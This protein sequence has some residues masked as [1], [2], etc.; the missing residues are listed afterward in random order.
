MEKKLEQ[1][2]TIGMVTPSA[3]APALFPERYNRGIEWL[4]REGFLIKEGQ[5]VL[6]KKGLSSASA[7][8]RAQD[9][10]SLFE[11]ESVSLIMATIGGDFASE[12]LPYLDWD[13]IKKNRKGMIGYSD[14]SVLLNAI[15]VKGHQVVY[16]GPTLMTE[17][18]EYPEPPVLSRNKLIEAFDDSESYGITPSEYLLGKGT[19]WAL[20]PIQRTEQIPVIQKTIR[21]GCAEGVVLGG[22]LEALERIRGTEYWADYTGAIMLAETVEEKF[23]EKKWR[24]FITDYR[25]M[26]VL[27]KLSGLVIGQKNW[28]IE[29]VNK[30]SEMLTEATL[31]NPI[32][33]LYGLPFGHISPIATF[34][35]FTSA[36]LD[37]DQMLLVYEK[38]F[39]YTYIKR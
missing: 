37:A 8:E 14:I 23:D 38:P 20:P 10:N 30:L 31:E 33:I 5:Y 18:A 27:Q 36:K 15:G 2:K 34:P 32:P 9:I 7:I 21:S 24:A 11:D 22:C 39:K 17:I 25:N 16:Y 4:I 12:I 35:L 3:P 26:G 6:S 28:S 1:R 13:K 19:D 29:E